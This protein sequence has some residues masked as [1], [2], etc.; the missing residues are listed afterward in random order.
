MTQFLS[1]PNLKIVN[2]RKVDRSRILIFQMVSQSREALCMRCGLFCTRIYDHRRV[3]VKDAPLRDHRVIWIVKKRRF[4][5]TVCKRPFTELVEGI[6]SHS[7]ITDRLRR[8]LLFDGKKSRTLKDVARAVGL[9]LTSVQRHFYSAL[10]VDQKRHL[11]YEWPTKIAIDEKRFGKNTHGYGAKFHTIVTDVNNHRVYDVLFTKNSKLLFAQLKDSNG[12][13]NVQH[14]SMDLSEGYRGLAKALFP[15]AQITADRFHVEK[16]LMPAINRRRKLISGDRRK[17]PIGNLLLRSSKRLNFFE[18]SVIDRYLS[19]HEELRILYAFKE[20]IKMFYRTRGYDRAK[21]VMEFML[22]ELKNYSHIREL[23]TL[24]ST[25]TRW[26]LEILNYFRTGLNN[27]IA[28]GFNNKI[29]VLK[30]NAYGYMNEEH[31]RLRVLSA[32]F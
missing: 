6:F 9:T 21:N 27:G 13:E 22:S 20:R 28:E 30:N 32:C 24:S 2:I 1:L 11:N 16:L 15:N 18:R 10:R 7:R 25:L 8:H 4:Y 12:L 23:K 5:C 17:N 31:F 26:K 19:P 3:K 14:V 29:S